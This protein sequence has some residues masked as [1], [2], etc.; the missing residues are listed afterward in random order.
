[1][2]APA[3]TVNPKLGRRSSVWPTGPVSIVT[4]G[5]VSSLGSTASIA[6]VSAGAATP[7]SSPTE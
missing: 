2:L 6:A 5:G 7:T 1:M 3:E 4:V